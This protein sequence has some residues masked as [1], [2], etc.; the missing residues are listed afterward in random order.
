M[1]RS[2]LRRQNP[3]TLRA[4]Q[5][6]LVGLGI[7]LALPIAVAA[8]RI[9]SSHYVAT[10]DIATTE[11]RVRDVW[12]HPVTLGP[13]SR[14]GWHHPGP[15]LFWMF[16]VLYNLTGHASWSLPMTVGIVN[17][18]AVGATVWK[19][20]QRFGFATT[21]LSCVPLALF[22]HNLGPILLGSPWNPDVIVLP[23]V[24]VVLLAWDLADGRF[25]SLPWFIVVA[26]FCAQSHIGS[27]KPILGFGKALNLVAAQYSTTGQWWRGRRTANFFTGE[28]LDIRHL[29]IPWLL[30]MSCTLFVMAFAKCPNLRAPIAATMAANVGALLGIAN[31]S[32]YAFTYLYRWLEA[33]ALITTVVA[34]ASGLAL[35]RHWRPRTTDAPKRYA[36][37]KPRWFYAGIAAGIA[38][39]TIASVGDA[40]RWDAAAH[41]PMRVVTGLS[42]DI[43]HRIGHNGTIEIRS[44]GSLLAAI[45]AGSILLQLEK[46]DID[47]T[48][49][50]SDELAAGKFHVTRDRRPW[51][52]VSTEPKAGGTAP[53]FV[54]DELTPP[55]RQK[56]DRYLQ[57]AI[58]LVTAKH[59]ND[60]LRLGPPPR[61]GIR[62][63]IYEGS[64]H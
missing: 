20:H 28:D 4:T 48:A 15:L 34:I 6:T 22:L 53:I 12:R 44:T 64:G 47:A 35:A 60:L 33:V 51:L 32:G 43:E 21:A 41:A 63:Y 7:V 23:F 9:A 59:F 2:Y 37:R 57:R 42:R 13:Y 24:V 56:V 50:I 30:L 17:M 36:A 18:L 27:G 61:D 29:L 5:W 8:L 40:S 10:G 1:I 62:Y 26:S 11:L 3:R 19:L 39:I 16:S 25:R 38:V 31:I 46:D 45:A 55:Q 14:F 54:G 49:P 58:A 52:V